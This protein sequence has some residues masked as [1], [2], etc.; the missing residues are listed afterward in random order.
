VLF[1][2]KSGAGPKPAIVLL[3]SLF[4]K[5]ESLP[6]NQEQSLRKIDPVQAGIIEKLVAEP[7]MCTLSELLA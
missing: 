7:D 3:V 2:I 1:P 5:E 4:V 6:E